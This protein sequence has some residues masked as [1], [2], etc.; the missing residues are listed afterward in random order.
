MKLNRRAL[1][2]FAVLLAAL[3][4]CRRKPATSPAAPPAEPP[5]A[6]APQSAAARQPA[7]KPAAA[8]EAVQDRLPTAPNDS[9]LRFPIHQ[10]L[11]GAVHLYSM[12]NQK[13]PEDFATLVRQK[14]LKAMPTPPPGK[15][16]A[17]D[18]NRMQVVIL[19]Q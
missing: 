14:Y 11:T 18:R 10:E 6:A 7:A 2:L 13:M 15:K 8:K 9:S 19:D 4:G 17:L 5:L 16:F 1:S 12:D 3:P